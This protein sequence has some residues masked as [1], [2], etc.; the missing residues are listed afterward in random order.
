MR[1]IAWR[2]ISFEKLKTTREPQQLCRRPTSV[3]LPHSTLNKH[4]HEM[5]DVQH[6]YCA[7]ETQTMRKVQ[8]DQMAHRISQDLLRTVLPRYVMLS[9]KVK[10]AERVKW[11]WGL[12]HTGCSIA[13][14]RNGLSFFSPKICSVPWRPRLQVTTNCFYKAH[15]ARLSKSGNGSCFDYTHS[16]WQCT[17]EIMASSCPRRLKF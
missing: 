1:T 3:R 11:E 16:H 2:E 10:L 13:P 9:C 5:N 17:N 7:A 6:V 15:H 12:K 4:H 14:A 8:Q